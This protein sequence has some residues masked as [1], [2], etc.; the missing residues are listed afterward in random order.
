[1]GTEEG[2]VS[3]LRKDSERYLNLDLKY[4]YMAVNRQ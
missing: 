1:M 4:Q 2:T 3:L